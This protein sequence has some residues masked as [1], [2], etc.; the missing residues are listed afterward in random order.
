MLYEN[1]RVGVTGRRG[2]MLVANLVA[3][4]PNRISFDTRFLLADDTVTY[5][6]FVVAPRRGSG[7]TVRLARASAARS[8]IVAFVDEAGQP[9]AV[10][11]AGRVAGRDQEVRVGYDGETFIERLGDTNQVTLEESAGTCEASFAFRPAPGVQA[12]IGPIR[13]IPI[14]MAQR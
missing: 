12:R 9:L 10:G 5:D 8:A 13:C 1:R 7:A 3:N 6:T 2:R 11:T 14:R 4:Q